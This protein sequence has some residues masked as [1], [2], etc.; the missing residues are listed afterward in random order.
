MPRPR[1]RILV[2]QHRSPSIR[3]PPLC[4]DKTRGNLRCSQQSIRDHCLRGG[5]VYTR[6]YRN[7]NLSSHFLFSAQIWKS[8]WAHQ[9][10]LNVD[11]VTHDPVA[12]SYILGAV[13]TNTIP[14]VGR[15][16]R[17]YA[18][19]RTDRNGRRVCPPDIAPTPIPKAS[20]EHIFGPPLVSTWLRQIEKF[21]S[22][23]RIGSSRCEPS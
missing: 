6:D 10:E 12:S 9:T 19:F 11:G 18:G 21:F 13:G 16:A 4:V 2:Q 14:A 3:K 23:Q 20:P 15:I 8:L 1:R 5:Q 22:L 17:A 7:S